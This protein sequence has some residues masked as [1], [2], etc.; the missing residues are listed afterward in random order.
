MCNVEKKWY[1][2]NF[3]VSLFI[4]FAILFIMFPLFSETRKIDLNEDLIFSKDEVTE[5]HT[6]IEE[7]QPFWKK[8]GFG[9]GYRGGICYTG[10]HF[11]ENNL[12]LLEFSGVI[13]SINLIKGGLKYSLN[14]RVALEIGSGYVWCSKLKD[15]VGLILSIPNPDPNIGYAFVVTSDWCFSGS[16]LFLKFYPNNSSFIEI[17]A[18]FFKASTI[19]SLY[20]HTSNIWASDTTAHVQRWCIGYAVA[21]GLQYSKAFNGYIKPY[22]NLQFGTGKEYKNNAPWQWK[23]KLSFGLTGLFAGLKFEIGGME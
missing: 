23:E 4:I 21:G 14:K 18:Y 19:E 13:Y 17:S 9:I 15:R 8:L 11:M 10:E 22:I 7:N 1:R 2:K 12:N 6:L 20:S 5:E 3:C 16:N